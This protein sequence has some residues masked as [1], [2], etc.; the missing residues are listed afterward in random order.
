MDKMIEF[1]KRVSAVK[2]SANDIIKK[3][4]PVRQKLDQ[5]NNEVVKAAIGKYPKHADDLP[6]A[7]KR[8]VDKWLVDAQSVIKEIDVFVKYTDA[9]FLLNLDEC[10]FLSEVWNGDTFDKQEL[11]GLQAL[12]LELKKQ[13]ANM[14]RENL[15]KLAVVELS[16]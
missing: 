15:Y 10:P 3:M 12:N 7:L 8:V 1:V 14:H 6:D 9:G 5:A 16:S 13:F 2:E 4:Q 11:D